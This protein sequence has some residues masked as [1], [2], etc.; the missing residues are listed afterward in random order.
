MITRDGTV[1]HSVPEQCKACQRKLPFAYLGE[2]R[3]VFD[4]PPLQFEVTEH[5]AMQA[6]CRC[7]Q[8]HTGQFPV[9]VNAG[10][11]YGPRA[12][13]AMVH[14][15]QNHAVSVQRTAA[16]MQDFFGLTVSQATVV[17]AAQTGAQI[18]QPTVQA[19]GQA[20]VSSAVLHADESGMRV[21]KKHGIDCSGSHPGALADNQ[22]YLMRQ[23]NENIRKNF[24]NQLG[25]PEFMRGVHGGPKGTNRNRLQVTGRPYAQHVSRRGVIQDKKNLPGDI[26]ALVDFDDPFARHQGSVSF[27]QHPV[28]YFHLG[29]PRGLA[30]QAPNFEGVA[31]TGSGEASVLAALPVSNAF[32]PTVVSCPNLSNSEQNSSKSR[33]K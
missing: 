5:H 20:A 16:L 28:A 11:Q 2:T 32:S 15:N 27:V 3:Q 7:G 26:N 12:Q 19:I 10:V 29:Q 6:I 33:S 25:E 21:A 8:V 9:G 17:K 30:T 14:L 31:K 23:G 22:R 24:A 18:L 4:L 13:A 1:I